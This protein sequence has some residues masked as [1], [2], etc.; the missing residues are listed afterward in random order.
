MQDDHSQNINNWKSSKRGA[1]TAINIMAS[2]RWKDKKGP[3]RQRLQNNQL[4]LEESL[5]TTPQSWKHEE[6][7]LHKESRDHRLMDFN[8]H[9]LTWE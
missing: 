7:K 9:T 2:K 5:M 6:L 8:I 4:S 3:K 1:Y